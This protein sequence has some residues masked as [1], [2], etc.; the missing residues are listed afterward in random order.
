MKS[1]KQ[2]QFE[3]RAQDSWKME[4]ALCDVL[5]DLLNLKRDGAIDA[6]KLDEF[7]AEKNEF[8]YKHNEFLDKCRAGDCAN[9]ESDYQ[10]LVIMYTETMKLYKKILA[11]KRWLESND[12]LN[13]YNKLSDDYDELLTHYDE[14]LTK[15]F[16]SIGLI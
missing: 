14:L 15:Y 3:S 12:F 11:V 13:D 5:G 9:F 4:R 8:F 10:K 7:N 1:K 2:K 6:A 16:R